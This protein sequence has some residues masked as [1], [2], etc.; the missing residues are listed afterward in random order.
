MVFDIFSLELESWCS[1]VYNRGR[2]L[3][4]DE[5]IDKIAFSAFHY[6]KSR[7]NYKALGEKQAI[8]KM[9][10]DIFSLELESRQF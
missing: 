3:K 5:H 6:R 7:S 9:V 2:R 4:R 8:D 1:I 10:F